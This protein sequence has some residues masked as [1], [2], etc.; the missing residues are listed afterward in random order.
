[1]HRFNPVLRIVVQGSLKRLVSQGQS[2]GDFAIPTEQKYK[3]IRSYISKMPSLSTTVTKVLE[4]CSNSNSSPNDL[5][6]VISL[7]PVLTGQLLK[8]VNS[9]YY[10][11]PSEVRSSAHAIILLGLNT[12]RNLVLS[13]AILASMS[14]KEPLRGFSMDDF[15]AHSICVGV[16]A[17]SLAVIKGVPIAER[18]GYFVAGL[19]HDLG[20]IPINRQFPDGY[21]RALDIVKLEQNPLHRAEDSVFGFDHCLIGKIIAEKWQLGDTIVETLCYHHDPKSAKEQN[22]N[23]I[24]IVALANIYANIFQIGSS[25]DPYPDDRVLNYLLKQLGINWSQLSGLREN[26]L[27]D[28]EKAK[29]FLRVAKRR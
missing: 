22:R 23:F 2:M 11:L 20:K 28:I 3:Q 15:W 6:R 8:V 26:V 12:V 21:I 4:I 29:I 24:A 9:A 16:T 14:G 7:D 27:D 18:E 25:G 1:M 17:K 13:T 5:S 10:S 19:L